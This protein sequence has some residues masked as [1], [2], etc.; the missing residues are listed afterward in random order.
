MTHS[1][2]TLFANDQV[3][4]NLDAAVAAFRLSDPEPDHPIPSSARKRAYRDPRAGSQLA[5]VSLVQEDAVLKWVYDP[6]PTSARRTSRRAIAAAADEDVVHSFQF[7]EVPPNQ[8]IEALAKLDD[9]LTPTRGLRRWRNG[10]GVAIAKAPA[11]RLLLLV[12][13]TFSKGEMFFEEL[14]ATQ[15][16][17]AFLA[18]AEQTY[19]AVLTFDHPTLSMSPWL[20]A[21]DLSRAL[22]G[23]DG[24]IDV[25]CHS[26]GGLVT[27]WWLFHA[28]PP[29]KRVVFVGSPLEG[30]SLAA[31]ARLKAALDLLGNLARAVGTMSS[32]AATAVP[33]LAA[34]GGLMKILG[35][36]LSFGAGT[37]LVDA[38][39]A[40]VPGLASQSR[41]ANNYELLRLFAD[42]WAKPLELHSVSSDY[43]PSAPDAWWKF[44]Q[45]F[46][47]IPGRIADW[48]ADAIFDG[49][50]DLVV[51]TA[52]MTELGRLSI[53]AGRRLVYAA[54][55]GVHHCAYF[56]QPDTVRFLTSVVGL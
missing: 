42:Q 41:V 30:T 44:W 33:L 49:P 43:A 12:H 51:D 21:L 13:G 29:V 36:M 4:T 24:P 26:R 27:A 50:N 37:P 7:L 25:I 47:Q 56:R 11:G 6:P 40:V 18:T 23:A 55:K 39:I 19:D 2:G 15:E 3:R 34:T 48:G 53:P 32:S 52:S 46:R 20:N 17:Q 54:D 16:G 5:T 22:D 10:A 31:P 14:A 35:G 28:R 8:V 38:G 9:A 1:A 45:Y